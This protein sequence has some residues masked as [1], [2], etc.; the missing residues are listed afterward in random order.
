MNALRFC[1]Q[2]AYIAN[3]IHNID[4]FALCTLYM[5]IYIVPSLKVKCKKKKKI[6]KSVFT[7]WPFIETL[8]TVNLCVKKGYCDFNF[9]QEFR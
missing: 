9:M 1:M 5:Y 7:H 4:A 3:N 2:M 6:K 8:L